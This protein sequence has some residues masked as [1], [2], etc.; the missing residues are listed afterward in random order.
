MN[1]L[2]EVKYA[3]NP[4]PAKQLTEVAKVSIVKIE[5]AFTTLASEILDLVPESADRTSAI[6]R[7]LEAKFMSVQAITHTKPNIK[8]VGLQA[9]SHHAGQRSAPKNDSKQN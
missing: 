9:S 3:F 2:D 1:T 5:M 7:I 8:D 6:R 4:V